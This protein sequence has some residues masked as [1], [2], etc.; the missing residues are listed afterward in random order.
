MAVDFVCG[1]EVP[2]ENSRYFSEYD[3]KTW[4]FCSPDCK[5]KFDDHP[6][7]FIRERTTRELGIG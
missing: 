4:H 6:D 1:A 5:R 2:E 7:R 3:N